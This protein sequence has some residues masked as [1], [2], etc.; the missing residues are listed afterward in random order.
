M[1]LIIYGDFYRRRRGGRE[2]KREDTGAKIASS[3]QALSV[4]S[5]V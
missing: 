2:E 5:E 4:N 1:N 3:G